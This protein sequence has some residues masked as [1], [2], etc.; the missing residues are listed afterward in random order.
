MKLTETIPLTACL[1]IDVYFIIVPNQ[2]RLQVE[3]LVDDCITIMTWVLDPLQGPTNRDIS[4]RN[5]QSELC[6]PLE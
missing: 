2:I 6:Y 1:C 4:L 3:E 5:N